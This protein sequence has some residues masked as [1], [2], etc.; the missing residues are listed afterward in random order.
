MTYQAESSKLIDLL[1]IKTEK[2]F[3]L[4]K[5]CSHFTGK[6]IK[7]LS[8]WA[9]II[10]IDQTNF[11]KLTFFQNQLIFENRRKSQIKKLILNIDKETFLNPLASLLLKNMQFW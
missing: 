7:C 5:H 4:E 9:A 8:I 2:M 1:L 10:P 6:W 3:M 11:I